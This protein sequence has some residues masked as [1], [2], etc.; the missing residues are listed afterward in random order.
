MFVSGTRE[1]IEHLQQK[2]YERN[3]S[4]AAWARFLDSELSPGPHSPGRHRWPPETVR[5]IEL[6]PPRAGGRRDSWWV[7]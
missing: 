2:G 7:S 4:H 1:A 6:E 5:V 3:G